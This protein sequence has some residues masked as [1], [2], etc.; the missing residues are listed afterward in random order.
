MTLVAH[1][2]QEFARFALEITQR[3]D[4]FADIEHEKSSTK[5]HYI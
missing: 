4:V 5:Y 2:F 1:T 3:V